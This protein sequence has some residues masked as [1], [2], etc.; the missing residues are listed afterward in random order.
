MFC[1]FLFRVEYNIL[2]ML[3]FKKANMTAFFNSFLWGK[4]GIGLNRAVFHF[5][6]WYA[7]ARRQ[8]SLDHHGLQ[9]PSWQRPCPRALCSPAWSLTG[10]SSRWQ[11]QR[12]I[13]YFSLLKMYLNRLIPFLPNN[14][15]SLFCRTATFLKAPELLTFCFIPPLYDLRNWTAQLVLIPPKSNWCLI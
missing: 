1:I 12:G 15:Q 10:E 2:L 9:R 14:S 11:N 3:S 5:S 13:A 4:V 8:L 7:S 6:W